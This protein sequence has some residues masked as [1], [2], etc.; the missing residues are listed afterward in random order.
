MISSSVI[1]PGCNTTAAWMSV[2]LANFT[3]TFPETNEGKL[4][5]S[6][7]STLGFQRQNQFQ[8]IKALSSLSNLKLKVNHLPPQQK[9]AAPMAETPLLFRA[10]ITGLASSYPLS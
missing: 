1:R 3:T 4:D 5:V 9:P 6:S 2:E 10:V 7:Q 8:R